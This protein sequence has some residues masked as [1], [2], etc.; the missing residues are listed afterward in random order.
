[1]AGGWHSWFLSFSLLCHENLINNFCLFQ[2]SGVYNPGPVSQQ[3]SNHHYATYQ[4]Q[5]TKKSLAE[6]IGR[7]L[8]DKLSPGQKEPRTGCR[9]HGPGPSQLVPTYV[10]PVQYGSPGY[11]NQQPGS[12]LHYPWEIYN[13]QIIEYHDLNFNASPVTSSCACQVRN[14]FS[15]PSNNFVVKIYCAN[16]F[17]RS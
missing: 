9:T 13:G 5:K 16:Y 11:G 17:I 1:M 4:R 8:V 12:H 10:Y 7:S 14:Q 6:K 3:H 15:L 2:E